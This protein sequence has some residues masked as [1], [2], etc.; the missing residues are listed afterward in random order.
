MTF[1]QLY[2]L[3]PF[4]ISRSFCSC[5]LSNCLNNLW[6]SNSTSCNIRWTFT[7]C[8]YV[9][10][11][12]AR[13]SGIPSLSIIGHLLRARHCIVQC[14]HSSGK[15]SHRVTWNLHGEQ[16]RIDIQLW[17][18]SKIVKLLLWWLLYFFFLKELYSVGFSWMC[19]RRVLILSWID[20]MRVNI[21][22][23]FLEDKAFE[24]EIKHM[25][26]G[27]W[28]LRWQKHCVNGPQTQRNVCVF[29]RYSEKVYH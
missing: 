9:F 18:A 20:V 24:L 1:K 4:R 28:Y 26:G 19:L 22:K 6:A 12:I 25:L 29:L 5:Q 21:K 10:I 16:A 27:G 23:C 11:Q 2:I 8:V 3:E 15:D 13:H 7:L 14:G 17:V